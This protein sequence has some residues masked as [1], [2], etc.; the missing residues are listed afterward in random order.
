MPRSVTDHVTVGRVGRPHGIDGSFVVENASEDARRFE[1]GAALLVDGERLLVV[2]SKRAR[3]RP[4]IKLDRDVPRGV[5]LC[6][7]RADLPPPGEGSYYA[8]QLVGL[9]VDEEGGR[10]LGHVREVAPGVANDVLELDSGVMLPL[11]ED[12]VREVDLEAGRIVV[13]RGFAEAG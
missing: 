13:A 6:V 5:E 7:P 4:V 8:F 3:G 1:K 2:A 11:H 10:S 9:A 12:C